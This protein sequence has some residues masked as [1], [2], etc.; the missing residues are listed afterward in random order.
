MSRP[1]ALYHYQMHVLVYRRGPVVP[2]EHYRRT[3]RRPPP[4]TL[5]RSRKQH[6]AMNKAIRLARGRA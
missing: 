5:P 3:G 2:L 1:V 6:R 4:L